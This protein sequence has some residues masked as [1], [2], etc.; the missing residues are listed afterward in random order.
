MWQCLH[1]IPYTKIPGCGTQISYFPIFDIS[2][3]YSSLS[4]TPWI[5]QRSF[6]AGY[7]PAYGYGQDISL[8]LSPPLLSIDT[9]FA[10]SLVFPF[11]FLHKILFSCILARTRY[12]TCNSILYVLNCLRYYFAPTLWY[13]PI[14]FFFSDWQVSSYFTQSEFFCHLHRLSLLWTPRLSRGFRYTKKGLPFTVN[15]LLNLIGFPVL[16]FLSLYPKLLYCPSFSYPSKLPV[17]QK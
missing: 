15:P 14:V 12:D 5:P 3:N 13:P 6:W 7:L 2:S 11:A 10:V 8:P 17:L 16:N 9:V 1:S 4:N